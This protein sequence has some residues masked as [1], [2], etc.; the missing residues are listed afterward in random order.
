MSA[1]TRLAE[2]KD[3][4]A[5]L[6][7]MQV[8]QKYIYVGSAFV[9]PDGPYAELRAD[10]AGHFG[11][12]PTEVIMVGSGKLGFSIRQDRRYGLFS[13]DSDID[14]AIVSRPFFESI[15]KSLYEY[16]QSGGWW[17][18][19]DDF[20]HFLFYGW[21]RPDK[22]PPNNHFAVAADWWEFFQ[23]L[24]SS[25]KFGPYRIRAG[26]YYD[27]SF[28]ESFQTICIQQCIDGAL[29]A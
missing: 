10:I 29:P 13:D 11:I 8:L 22:L 27:L 9:L 1:E 26:L 14:V 19:I 28:L 20:K 21:I 4:V 23:A 15:W 24:A 5:H 3:D 16:K 18:R 6:S 2:F 7:A 25:G 17:P 12:H